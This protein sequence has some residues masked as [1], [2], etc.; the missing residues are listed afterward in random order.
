MV[1]RGV[2]GLLLLCVPQVLGGDAKDGVPRPRGSSTR[3]STVKP[4]DEHHSRPIRTASVSDRS[5]EAEELTRFR[6]VTSDG[7]LVIYDAAIPPDSDPNRD[8]ERPAVPDNPGF[9]AYWNDFE[10]ES[11]YVFDRL[12]F[13]PDDVAVAM[14]ILQRDFVL[15]PVLFTSDDLSVSRISSIPPVTI[16]VLERSEGDDGS[17]QPASREL[18]LSIMGFE[19]EED[20]S[21]GVAGT[22][23]PIPGPESLQIGPISAPPRGASP[24]VMLMLAV[25]AAGC[26]DVCTNAPRIS[27]NPCISGTRGCQLCY[28]T[29]LTGTPCPDEGDPCTDNVCENGS[30]THPP[31]SG[32]Q[33]ADDGNPCTDNV[34]VSGECTHPPWPDGTACDA[35]GDTCTIDM[36]SG[37][38]C[39]N[40]S[41]IPCPD[42]GNP[43]TTEDCSSGICAHVPKDNGTACDDGSFCTISD[44]CTEGACGGTPLDCNDNN[45]C[46]TEGPCLPD[47]GCQRQWRD[48]GDG[49]MC[50]LDTCNPQTGAC[51][52]APIDCDS[53]ALECDGLGTPNTGETEIFGQVQSSICLSLP[54]AGSGVLNDVSIPVTHRIVT[55]DT[56]RARDLY[57]V[58]RLSL[59]SGDPTVVDIR[60]LD[61]PYALNSPI[62][63][64]ELGHAGCGLHDWHEGVTSFTFIPRNAGEV[65]LKAQVDPDPECCEGDGVPTV[66]AQ[67]TVT[68]GP[69]VELSADPSSI[70]AWSNWVATPYA[71][72]Q[73]DVTWLPPD[74]EGILAIVTPVVGD[75]GFVPPSEGTLRRES[76]TRWIYGA[77]LERKEELCPQ[78]VNVRIAAKAGETELNRVSVRVLPIHTWWTHQHKHFPGE[79]PHQP[80]T[81]DF[82]NDYDYLFWKYAGAMLTTGGEFS[83]VA[84]DT[85]TCV[86]CG[87]DSCTY[88]CTSAVFHSTVFGTNTFRG[89][90]NQAAS[91]IGHELM[92]TTIAGFTECAAYRW[93]V[94]HA[95]DTGIASCDTAYLDE[96]R[97][98]LRDRQCS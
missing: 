85:N 67:V 32:P 90:E 65:I 48:C 56:E 39:T 61:A 87:S 43:C 76:A 68:I 35:D 10:T 15:D 6:I 27:G 91:I 4:A 18:V 3:D 26:G 44:A 52:S 30:C 33:C 1:R 11:L 14:G 9:V 5:S 93:E 58:L 51:S 80:D 82:G 59:V 19:A 97:D 21:G 31:I 64:V 73:I 94:D 45:L 96:V 71:G 28:W 60:F 75:G 55:H 17:W 22:C 86:P 40:V 81:W 53:V 72:S 36:C 88:A 77:F 70:P 62:S 7:V 16:L 34:C 69:P 2:L 66:E 89:S 78:G 13:A 47:V 29:A 63:V 24:D 12:L 41:N 42:E 79:T 20:G 92:H 23:W 95:G 8:R 57:G 25:A 37:G 54:S 38:G 83:S 98:Q 50:T 74:C 46:T 49:N 84:I